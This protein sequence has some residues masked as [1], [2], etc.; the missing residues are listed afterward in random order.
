MSGT[1]EVS[2]APSLWGHVISL[3]VS[4]LFYTPAFPADKSLCKSH[5]PPSLR[6]LLTPEA[7][8]YLTASLCFP[9]DVW[10]LIGPALGSSS[11]EGQ[12]ERGASM[13]GALQLLSGRWGGA[14][15]GLH[16]EAKAQRPATADRWV[17]VH[18]GVYRPRQ[19]H[20]SNGNWSSLALSRSRVIW[21]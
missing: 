15:Q 4:S 19:S 12:E 9:P 17:L 6:D 8:D 13:A 1:T 18:D 10:E 20:D 7:S 21:K 11:K 3:L 16:W 2:L 5:Q 14:G